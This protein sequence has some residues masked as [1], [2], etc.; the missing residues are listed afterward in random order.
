M[1]RS[2][3]FAESLLETNGMANEKSVHLGYFNANRI[4]AQSYGEMLNI[5][6]QFK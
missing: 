5:D 4:P 2:H 3:T 6:L 1:F